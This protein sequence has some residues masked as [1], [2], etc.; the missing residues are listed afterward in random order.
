MNPPQTFQKIIEAPMIPY[1]FG[2]IGWYTMWRLQL[3]LSFLDYAMG[4][5][6]VFLPAGIRTLAVLVFGIRGA[7]GVFVGSLLST[8]EYM[9]HVATLDFF[10][11]ALISA[12]SAFS[13]YLMMRLVCW[14]RHIGSDLNELTFRDLLVIVFTQGLLSATLHQIIY[15]THAIETAYVDPTFAQ[16]CRLWSAMA[17][18]DIVGSMI[19]MLSA[20]A[21][22]GA[23]Q[24]L[25]RGAL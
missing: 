24:S 17:A 22:A 25:R 3:Q 8:V 1:L 7:V 23:F 2:F 16:L 6:I 9:G 11:V 13:S 19:L 12:V 21:L 20:V 15:S 18:G 5:S 14:R 4:V 10:N